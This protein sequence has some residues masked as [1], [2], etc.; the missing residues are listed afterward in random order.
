M[1][2]WSG[3]MCFCFPLKTAFFL[4]IRLENSV[5]KMSKNLFLRHSLTEN[6]VF[7]IENFMFLTED[8][9][10]LIENFIFLNRNFHVFDSKFYAFDFEFRIL[11]NNSSAID[12]KYH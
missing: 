9:M 2:T 11:N 4:Y 5:T 7:L 8:F 6:F 1:H 10:F 12:A 3:F